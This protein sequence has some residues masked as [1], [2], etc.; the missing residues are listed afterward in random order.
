MGKKE[1]KKMPVALKRFLKKYGRFPKGNELERFKK[2]CS[3][4]VAKRVYGKGKKK[5]HKKKGHKHNQTRRSGKGRRHSK[6]W[7]F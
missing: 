3:R 1:K 4:S 5:S 6:G 7:V 2:S